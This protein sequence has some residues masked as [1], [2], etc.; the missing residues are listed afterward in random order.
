METYL[1]SS[2]M[3]IANLDAV[4]LPHIMV[5]TVLETYFEVNLMTDF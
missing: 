1:I 3:L 5:M 4:F 2:C